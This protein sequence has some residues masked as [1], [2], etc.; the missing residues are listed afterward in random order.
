M[1]CRYTL[2][3]GATGLVGQYLMRDLLMAGERL[4]V[5]VRAGKEGTAFERIDAIL[6][7]W[8]RELKT[9]L[10]RPVVLT[11][12][13]TASHCGLSPEDLS[14]I[15]GNCHR[16]LHNAAVLKFEGVDRSREPWVTNVG[17]TQNVLNLCREVGIVD[18]H[19]VSTA[20]VCGAQTG[21]V[22][23]SQLDNGQE[24]RND[25]E[26]SKFE[27]EKLVR[28]CNWIEPA[29]IYRPAVIAGDSHSGYTSSY[30]GLYLYLRLMA[31]LVPFQTAMVPR[32]ALVPRTAVMRAAQMTQAI[33]QTQACLLYTSPSPR[34]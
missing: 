23:E 29:T 9:H 7:R 18:L 11:G 4:A 32:T 13:I 21:V 6:G 5:I 3:T 24:F 30:H 1:S 17:G 22:M 20:Y 14:W 33:P 2:L 16:I 27:S 19:Y 10:P 8:E 12:C 28:N 26:R 25:Y 34:D 31:T 15:K